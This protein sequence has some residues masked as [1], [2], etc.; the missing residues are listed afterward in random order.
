PSPVAPAAAPSDR[1][2]AGWLDLRAG[3][4]VLLV[5]YLATFAVFY[6][7]NGMLNS[8]VPVFGAERFQ[9]EP[10][11]IGLLFTVINAL[12]IGAVLLGGRC[13]DRF[14][15]YR[16]LVPS[17][18]FLALAQAL[19][20][21]VPDTRT[22]IVVARVRGVACC[23]TPVPAM[24]MGAALAPR[25][26][27]RGIAVCRAVCDIAILAAPASMGIAIQAG[28]FGA[29]QWVNFLVCAAAVTGVWL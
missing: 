28:G 29:A 9:F 4:K 5:S 19:L 25:R 15:R 8:V 23:V 14:G 12:G 6:S 24:V 3:G 22:F 7:R 17:L 18:V 26:R 2:A 10:F 11:Q 27:A 20:L 16:V 13:A 1:R 21:T